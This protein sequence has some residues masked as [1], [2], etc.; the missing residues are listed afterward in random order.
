MTV[1]GASLGESINMSQRPSGIKAPSKIGKPAG[2]PTP[3]SGLPMPGSKAQSKYYGTG[4]FGL[5]MNY[6]VNC[7]VLSFIFR[8]KFI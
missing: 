5:L 3:R 2:L 1:T 4:V 6:S 8:L 7:F